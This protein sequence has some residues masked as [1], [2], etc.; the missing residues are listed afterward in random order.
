MSKDNYKNFALLSESGHAR[1][2]G[3]SDREWVVGRCPY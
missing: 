3:G 1:K 2:V